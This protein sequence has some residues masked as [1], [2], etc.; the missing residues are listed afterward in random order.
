MLK[1]SNYIC[2]IAD[3]LNLKIGK[4]DHSA[5][6]GIAEGVQTKNSI[7]SPYLV[8]AVDL[9]MRLLEVFLFPGGA[10][11]PSFRPLLMIFTTVALLVPTL[12]A[13]KSSTAEKRAFLSLQ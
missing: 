6:R 5:G 13:R 1:R 7:L 10:A 8:P 2:I 4:R 3:I 9:P 12:L 11:Q